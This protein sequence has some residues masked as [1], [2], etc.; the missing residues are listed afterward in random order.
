MLDISVLISFLSL[1]VFLLFFSISFL[2]IKRNNA[3]L[4]KIFLF[5]NFLSFLSFMAVFIF[6][7]N[8]NNVSE[9]TKI[10]FLS[11]SLLC[12]IYLIFCIINFNFIRLRL[13]FLPYFFLLSLICYSFFL[14]E[15]KYKFE[16]NLF[17]NGLISAHIICS[18]LSYSLL[19][20]SVLTS[21]AFYI[22]E[23]NLKL[24]NSKRSSLIILLP[25]I[26]ESEKITINLLYLTQFFLLTSFL[27]G[28]YYYYLYSNYIFF[29]I[30]SKSI[31]SIITFFLISSLLIIRL[32]FGI[33]GKKIFNFVIV[34]FLFINLSYFG[35][36]IYEKIN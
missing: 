32:Y 30:N 22:V 10:L 27:T 7:L 25:S 1:I 20:F 2:N 29:L 33:T 6:L 14:I 12:L 3:L 9:I 23:K 8:K 36:K 28:F 16:S 18:L 35:L 17:D 13:L 31:L 15:I 4:K 24:P 11:L 26:Y 34:S 21:T 5:G 19:T